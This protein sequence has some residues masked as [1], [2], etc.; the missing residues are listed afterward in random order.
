MAQRDALSIAR[1][2][3]LGFGLVLALAGL[4][5]L[6]IRYMTYKTLTEETRFL[7]EHADLKF[8]QLAQT[9]CAETFFSFESELSDW[10]E[11]IVV[12][13]IGAS[14]GTFVCFI[15]AMAWQLG[16]WI[17]HGSTT[18]VDEA[19][20]SQKDDAKAIYLQESDDDLSWRRP[21]EH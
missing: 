2:A 16:S 6:A 15:I 10:I 13:I 11:S 5:Y 18:D 7:C 14:L 3:L 17:W 19:D 4:I 1:R 8:S 21:V 9:K 12:V 20:T